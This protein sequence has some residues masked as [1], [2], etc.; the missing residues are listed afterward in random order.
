MKYYH[1]SSIAGL[2]VL[3]PFATYYQNK[4][5]VYLS[6]NEVVATFYILKRDYMWFTY[7]FTLEGIPLY[8]ESYKGCLEEFYGKLS[9]Y[10]YVCE[11]IFPC[12]NPTGIQ[13]AAVSEEAVPVTECISIENCL[14][15]LLQYE[16]QGKLLIHR[17]SELSQKQQDSNT[18]MVLSAIKN[19]NLLEGKHPLSSFVKEKFPELWEQSLLKNR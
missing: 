1:G 13:V 4:P 3:Q 11:G 17:F 14:D 16:A 7:G 19:L 15:K 2:T 12:P 10:L 18:Q 6:L 5:Y 9:G 8:T